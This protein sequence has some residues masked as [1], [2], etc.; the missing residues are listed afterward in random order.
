MLT[1][2]IF[3]MMIMLLLCTILQIRMQPLWQTQRASAWQNTVTWM[4]EWY[5]CFNINRNESNNG[6]PCIFT[7]HQLRDRFYENNEIY[8]LDDSGGIWGHNRK[9]MKCTNCR[10]H[11]NSHSQ[12]GTSVIRKHW[13]NWTILY[14][15]RKWNLYRHI[16]TSMPNFY[17][18]CAFILLMVFITCYWVSLFSQQQP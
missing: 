10:L 13:S 6:S 14:R 9:C 7:S 4:M 1:G 11:G 16:G 17:S 3:E 18:E 12:A 5:C 8:R 15:N 2:V